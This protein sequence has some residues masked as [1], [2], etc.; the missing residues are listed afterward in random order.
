MGQG[1]EPAEPRDREQRLQQRP[2]EAEDQQQGADVADHQVLG[3]VGE[4]QLLSQVRQ[5]RDEGAGDQRD[6]GG[7]AD[8]VARPA[9][10]ALPPARE[11]ARSA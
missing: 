5:R 3:H 8:D 10:A 1:P 4:Q 9:P 2:G 11:I 7:E 6:P